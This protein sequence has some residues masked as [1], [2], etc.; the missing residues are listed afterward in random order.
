MDSLAERPYKN[1]VPH[2]M[3]P[4]AHET[5]EKFLRALDDLVII[6]PRPVPVFVQNYLQRGAIRLDIHPAPETVLN[7]IQLQTSL[8]IIATERSIQIGEDPAYTLYFRPECT[9]QS[10]QSKETAFP[11]APFMK[12][13]ELGPL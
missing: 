7:A 6:G 9:D 10:T 12:A 11:R 4:C 8:P 2:F 5:A 3:E 13:P 1:F